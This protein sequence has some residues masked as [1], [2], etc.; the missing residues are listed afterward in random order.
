M[1]I[2]V[3]GLSHK[4][5][6]VEIREKLSFPSDRA[7]EALKDLTGRKGITEGV[8]LSTCNR[9][10]VIAISSHIQ[11]GIETIKDFIAQF[12]ELSREVLDNHLYSH[13]S[14]EAIKHIFRVASS[15][16]SMVVGEPQILGQMKD[17][18]QQALD[19]NVT[20]LILNKLFRKGFSVAKR[21]RTETS[22]ASSAVSISYAAVELAKKIFGDLGDKRVML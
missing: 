9:V 10:E 17:A 8:I 11:D 6:P 18:Y 13:T 19:H 2:I 15:L 5:A 21:V 16:D 4:T 20:G 1:N 12:N 7:T 22:I 3:V 14:E